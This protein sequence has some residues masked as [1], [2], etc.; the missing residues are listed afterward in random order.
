MIRNL[1]GTVKIVDEELGI[2]YTEPGTPFSAFVL[3]HPIYYRLH[4]STRSTFKLVDG[5]AIEF[6][7]ITRKE[8][9]YAMLNKFI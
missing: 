8:T 4:Y 7:L 1:Q 2:E 6:D 9:P 3:F 5:Q